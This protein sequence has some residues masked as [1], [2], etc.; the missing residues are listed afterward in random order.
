MT[1]TERDMLGKLLIEAAIIYDR[2]DFDKTKISMTI[3]ILESFFP[4]S[5]AIHICEAISKYMREPKNTQFP[6][7]AR[8]N[9]YL[10]PKT[11]R[12]SQAQ[13]IA[14]R[15]RESVTRFGYTGWEETKEYV[16]E[17]GVKVIQR[18]GGWNLICQELGVSIQPD[19]F[20][21]Q[22]RELVKSQ[23]ELDNNG[24]L[25]DSSLLNYQN[26]NLISQSQPMQVESQNCQVV[27]LIKTIKIKEIEK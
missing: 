8:L 3:N 11:S 25:N 6:A 26:R 21:A 18:F 1:Q 12:D 9:E 17:I 23:L 24:K 13:E 7:P 16:G 15:V 10:R 19:T 27:D 20:Y 5:S 22:C 2:S 14:S 4:E